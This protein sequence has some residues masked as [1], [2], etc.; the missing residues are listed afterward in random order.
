MHS[1]RNHPSFLSRA[2][3]TPNNSGDSLEF[4]NSYGDETRAASYATLAFHNTYYLAFRDLPKLFR[5]HVKG[6]KAI[7]FGCGTGRSTRFL[8]QQGFSAVG[9]DISQEMIRKAKQIDPVGNYYLITDG[10]YDQFDKKSYDLIL[11]AFTFDNIPLGKK[12]SLFL[13][14]TR[15]LHPKGKLISITS[16]PEMYTHEWASFTTEKFPENKQAKNGDV[17]PIITKD[18][19]DNR[20]CYDIFCTP[21]EYSRI[22]ADAGLQIVETIKPLATGDE[23]YNW[24]NETRIAPWIIYVLQSKP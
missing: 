12:Q 17:V 16:S 5:T 15:L 23:S 7:D 13:G 1:I 4:F 11:S 20:P 6:K 10:D 21:E 18:F 2:L 9:V 3:V 19:D 14:L 22:Y 24:I 8:K